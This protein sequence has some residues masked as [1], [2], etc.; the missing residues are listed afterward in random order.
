MS[1]RGQ[2]ETQIVVRDGVAISILGDTFVNVWQAP[3]REARSRWVYDFVDD[4]VARSSD[5]FLALLVILPSASPPDRAAR[6]ENAVRLRRL[7][8]RIRGMAT[9]ALGDSFWFSIVRSIMTASVIAS[10]WHR[11]H[12]VASTIAGGI[13]KLRDWSSAGTPGSMELDEHVRRQFA[14]LGVDPGPSLTARTFAADE[15]SPASR[16]PP[17]QSGEAVRVRAAVEWVRSRVPPAPMPGATPA[18]GMELGSSAVFRLLRPLGRGARGGM[19]VLWVAEHRALATEVVVKFLADELAAHPG[20]AAAIAAEAATTAQLRSPHVV[21]VLDHGVTEE[22]VPFIVMEY[23]E[24]CD[25]DSWLRTRG[26][27]TLHETVAVVHAVAKALTKTHAAG[28]LHF[29]VKPSNVF[30]CEGDD[31]FVKLLDFG[32]AQAGARAA[33]DP[34]AGTWPGTPAYMSPEQLDGADVDARSDVWALGVVAFE[35]V[36]GTRLIRGETRASIAEQVSH[37]A[38][39]RPSR[40]R[41]GLPAAFDAWFAIAC[42]RRPEGRFQSAASAA[43]ALAI[44]A[45]VDSHAALFR[46]SPESDQEGSRSAF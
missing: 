9:V 6:L 45:G 22:G 17:P 15:S 38:L 37:G 18:G 28:L 33:D 31:V 46:W 1:P 27:L 12:V 29:D 7:R 16:T 30:L 44:A 24:G 4:V 13:G 35:C 21:Q 19:G 34:D 39:P 43:A 3:A 8:S 32:V 10:G 14:A 26:P 20:A 25:L 42:S 41:A 23:L 11:Q 40:V 36:T 5:D 2:A